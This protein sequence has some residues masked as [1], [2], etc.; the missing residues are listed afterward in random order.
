MAAWLLRQSYT[1]FNFLLSLNSQTILAYKENNSNMEICPESL[2]AMLEYLYRTWPIRGVLN[3]FYPTRFYLLA[4]KCIL[5]G[6]SFLHSKT[7]TDH[8][9]MPMF[10]SSLLP[11]GRSGNWL[12]V[13]ASIFYRLVVYRT[14]CDYP[15]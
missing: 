10:P 7:K 11:L 14:C 1:F 9:L 8:T 15:A 2:G 3:F 6:G 13:F 4:K 5:F 12:R